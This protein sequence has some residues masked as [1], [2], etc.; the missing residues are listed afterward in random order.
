MSYRLTFRNCLNKRIEFYVQIQKNF[1]YIINFWILKKKSQK[2]DVF[3][4]SKNVNLLR[5][6]LFRLK[7]SNDRI[8]AWNY[9]EFTPKNKKIKG[10]PWNRWWFKTFRFYHRVAVMSGVCMCILQSTEGAWMS[11]VTE[12]SSH[13]CS[14]WKATEHHSDAMKQRIPF[15]MHMPFIQWNS[16][17]SSTTTRCSIDT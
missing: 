3:N 16:S 17:I 14:K 13:Q 2:N 15:W 9:V 6:K 4:K 1:G 8:N 5:K 7:V 10:R 12:Y 11:T